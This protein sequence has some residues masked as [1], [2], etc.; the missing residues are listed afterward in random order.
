MT[1]SNH[2]DIVVGSHRQ[3]L[4]KLQKEVGEGYLLVFRQD[5]TKYYPSILI[6]SR[7]PI[8]WLYSTLVDWLIGQLSADMCLIWVM[9]HSHLWQLVYHLTKRKI[10]ASR[11]PASQPTFGE[12][13]LSHLSFFKI[14]FIVS[15]IALHFTI[16][17]RQCSYSITNMLYI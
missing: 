8:Q 3:A 12:Y 7:C 6:V 15:F 10:D 2:K 1:P 4:P 11:G 17:H 9:I 13:C 16:S 5:R 14:F